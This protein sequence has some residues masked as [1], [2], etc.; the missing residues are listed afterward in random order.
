MHDDIDTIPIDDI[1]RKKIQR[2][3][4][5]DTPVKNTDSRQIIDN[6]NSYDR[7]KAMINRS[8]NDRIGLGCTSLP[9]AQQVTAISKHNDL[10]TNVPN[11]MKQ[12]RIGDNARNI[13][14]DIYKTREKIL[15]HK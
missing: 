5:N 4:K 8:F 9:G 13:G 7:D 11:Y 1:D 2:Q 3:M 12:L 14:L 10:R 6:I 15:F